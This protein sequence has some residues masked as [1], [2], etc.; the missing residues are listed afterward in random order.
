MARDK[1]IYTVPNLLSAYRIVTFPLLLYFILSGR[2]QVFAVFFAISLLTDIL[3]GWIARTFNLQSRL[4]ALLDSWADTG[5]FIL[6]FLGIW[7][8]RWP[9]IKPHSLIL[10]VYL[11]MW[12]LSYVFVFIKFHGLIGMHTYLFKVTGYLQGA[13][14]MIL[15][16]WGFNPWFFYI[17]IGWGIL[18]CVE[19]IIIIFILKTPRTDLKGLY[20]VLKSK[21]Q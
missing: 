18:A 11:G 1:N 9:D 7:F 14:F 20:W 10:F 13:F 3:D 15:F 21:D 8:F 16:L 17:A 12:F 19:E 5:V 6:A 4:G 2:E